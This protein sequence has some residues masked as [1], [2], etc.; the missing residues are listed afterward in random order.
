MRHLST[1]LARHS[2]SMAAAAALIA[3]VVVPAQPASAAS[4]TISYSCYYTGTN[5][6]G[7]EWKAASC[8][9]WNLS[10]T[11]WNNNIE[12]VRIGGG[13]W[14]HLYD[15]TDLTGHLI[16]YPNDYV[17]K[18]LPTTLRNRASSVYIEC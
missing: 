1:L 15:N 3:F 2:R 17:I 8:G 13:G 12:S 11:T 16:S 6:S 9:G 7:S 14:V 4:C 18:N 5:A 10:G